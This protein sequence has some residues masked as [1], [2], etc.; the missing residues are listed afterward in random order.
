MLRKRKQ[1]FAVL[2]KKAV[3]S[4]KDENKNSS[5]DENSENSFDNNDD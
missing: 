4:E 1:S 5:D 2:S 3:K